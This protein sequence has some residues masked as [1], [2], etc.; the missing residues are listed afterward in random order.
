M[1]RLS[2]GVYIILQCTW[3]L[4]QTLAGLIFFLISLK[5]EHSFYHGAIKTLHPD[6]GGVSLGL[7]IFVSDEQTDGF[8]DKTAVHEFGHTIQ[9]LILGPLYL[10][11]V[12]IVSA[13]W[14]S[15]PYF[16]RLRI[17]KGISYNACITEHTANFLGEK[18]L[19]EQSTRDVY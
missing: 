13:L 19:R 11:T 3:G 17:K 18:L 6:I 7:F 16:R 9:S 10:F 1:K 14:C 8:S 2:Y 5:Y 4:P 12:G 15:L